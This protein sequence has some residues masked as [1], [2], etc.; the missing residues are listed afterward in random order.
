MVTWKQKLLHY[1]EGYFNAFNLFPTTSQRPKPK[2]RYE[3]FQDVEAEML[4]TLSDFNN[5]IEET[6][7]R[8]DSTLEQ[9]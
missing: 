5:T 3:Y 9:Q 4:K 1:L 7:K 8:A 6:K 2:T